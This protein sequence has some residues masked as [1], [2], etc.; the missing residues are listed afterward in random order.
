MYQLIRSDSP[1][2]LALSLRTT[3]TLISTLAP[4]LKLQ[5]ELFLSYLIDRLTPST[6]LPL[7]AHLAHLQNPS[8][9]STPAPGSVNT[10]DGSAASGSDTV[11]T[12]A[13]LPATP[14]PINLLPPVPA[15]TKEL[16]LET[17]AQIASRPGFMV[18]CWVNYD[19]GTENEDMFERLINF[20]TRVRLYR[21]QI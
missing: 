7:P 13:A 15:E 11:D 18:D 5:L 21:F 3:S 6:P 20:L 2:L 17:L 12:P 9:P 8:R 10:G 19:C 1:A 16:M 4:H 14:R